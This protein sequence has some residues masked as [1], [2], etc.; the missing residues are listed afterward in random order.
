MR[1]LEQSEV[2]AED[3]SDDE[4]DSDD[5]DDGA[6]S[7]TGRPKHT[8]AAP[9]A[10]QTEPLEMRSV[11]ISA[12]CRSA[13]RDA[14]ANEHARILVRLESVR[15]TSEATAARRE[16]AVTIFR[17]LLAVVETWQTALGPEPA[18]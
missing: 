1:A 7:T 8:P 11:Q 16:A 2:A 15:M 6:S 18:Q 12:R 4:D 14:L 13:L 17:G 3:S 9:A 10:L 5:D